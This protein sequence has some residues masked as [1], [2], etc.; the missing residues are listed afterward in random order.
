MYPGQTPFSGR[1]PIT[2]HYLNQPLSVN[3]K[4]QNM[5]QLNTTQPIPQ[6]SQLQTPID[7]QQKVGGLESIGD[8]S[9]F[10]FAQLLSPKDHLIGNT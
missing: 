3:Q 6:T 5:T 1:T 7:Y 4:N 2:E 10:N 8:G 9:A